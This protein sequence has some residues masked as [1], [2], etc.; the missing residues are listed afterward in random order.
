VRYDNLVVFG[1][2]GDD[3]CGNGHVS[4]LSLCG[5]CLAS[6]QQGISP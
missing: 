1:E 6:L 2:F 5:H 4:P 3:V